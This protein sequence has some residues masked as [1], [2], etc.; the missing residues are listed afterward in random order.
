MA[1]KSE[2]DLQKSSDMKVECAHTN[3]ITVDELKPNSKNPNVHTDEQIKLL[4]KIMRHQGVRNPIVVSKRSGLITKGH[5]RLEA[6]KLNGWKQFP[7]DVQ[8][9]K[10]AA[11]EYA[12]M[13]ADNKIAELAKSNIQMIEDEIPQ[14]KDLDLDLL[15][16]PDFQIDNKYVDPN[17][18]ELDENIPTDHEC[19]SC[20]YKW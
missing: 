1:K 6:A 11:L 14:L 9:Y 10:T 2:N 17:E 12:D 7:V 15:G 20:G 5:A 19:P 13:V 18:K 4:A 16:I 3:L 8:K